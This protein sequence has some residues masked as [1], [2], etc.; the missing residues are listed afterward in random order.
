MI[1][2]HFNPAAMKKLRTAASKA[3]NHTGYWL[4]YIH[5]NGKVIVRLAVSAEDADQLAVGHAY[6]TIEPLH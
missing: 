1:E 3:L 4:V 6:L 2:H 5:D